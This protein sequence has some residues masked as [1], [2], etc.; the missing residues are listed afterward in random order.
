[1]KLNPGIAALGTGGLLLYDMHHKLPAGSLH[2]LH[3]VGLSVIALTPREGGALVGTH[4]AAAGNKARRGRVISRH[5][6]RD[7]TYEIRCGR[8]QT[9]S[10]RDCIVHHPLFA[11]IRPHLGVGV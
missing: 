2:H 1:M 9:E 6:R 8:R 5:S 11:W 3:P 4:D 10:E 7:E